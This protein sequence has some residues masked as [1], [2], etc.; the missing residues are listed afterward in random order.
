MSNTKIRS[1]G[2]G[3]VK[4]MEGRKTLVEIVRGEKKKRSTNGKVRERRQGREIE[5]PIVRE[6]LFHHRVPK[7]VGKSCVSCSS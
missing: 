5:G 1:L 3:V 6:R 7:V 2:C 4:K